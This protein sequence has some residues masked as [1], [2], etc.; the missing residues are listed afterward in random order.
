MSN[1]PE[2]TIAVV[3]LETTGLSPGRHD[4][5]IEIGIVIGTPSGTVIR[6]YET[7]INP[8][9]D[10][11]PTR[12]HG[13]TSGELIHAPSFD[14]IAGDIGVMLSKSQV[15]AGH[16]VSFDWQFLIKEYSRLELELPRIPLLCTCRLSGM[17]SLAVTVH[18]SMG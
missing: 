14:A 9:R 13:I 18:P 3:D 10:I 2:P 6:E 17:G 7:L 1:G 16:N 15:I 8:R 12:I 4:R 5:V 11:G